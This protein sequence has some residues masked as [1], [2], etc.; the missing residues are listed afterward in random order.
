MFLCNN[1][2]PA[3]QSHHWRCQQPGCPARVNTTFWDIVRGDP[4]A[5]HNH[6]APEGRVLQHLFRWH[7]WV[8]I[9]T[10]QGVQPEAI[11]TQ[12]VRNLTQGQ[13]ELLGEHRIMVRWIRDQ[14]RGYAGVQANG[15][16][17][18]AVRIVGDDLMTDA[19]DLFLI[20]DNLGVPRQSRV[21]GFATRQNVTLLRGASTWLA[22]GTFSVSPPNF[23][24]F[25]VIHA[26]VGS[27]TLPLAFFIMQRR[28]ALDYQIALGMLRAV[29]DPLPAPNAPVAAATRGRP[30]IAQPANDPA[31]P[32]YTFTILLDFE[33]AQSGAFLEC[34][35]GT[36][37]RQGC[38]FHFR[39]AILRRVRNEHPLHPQMAE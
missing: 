38:F 29:M 22:D 21:I 37:S 33:P 31:G 4:T 16:A 8:L 27:Q 17:V 10:L 11:M 7:L 39:Q 35:G 18:E 5:G 9:P 26:Q 2:D 24:Q 1:S 28:T 12:A 20:G 34:F 36:I 32:V 13:R 30:R 25:W 23:G 19:G 15:V 3:R 14:Q 6:D